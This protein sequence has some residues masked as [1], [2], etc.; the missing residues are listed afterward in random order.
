MTTI[1]IRNNFHKLIDKIS[2][3]K[4]LSKFYSILERVSEE[5]D[6]QLWDR[7]TEEEKQ[8]LLFIDKESDLE[9][10]LINH[11]VVQEKHQKWLQK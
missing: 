10:N 11:S 5:K 4:V 9:E 2:N 1:E 7:L 3:D 6:G 8:E